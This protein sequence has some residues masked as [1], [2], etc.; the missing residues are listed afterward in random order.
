MKNLIGFIVLLGLS[1]EIYSQ[2]INVYESYVDTIL[3]G[4]HLQM[5]IKAIESYPG[6][7]SNSNIIN[8]FD[9]NT[10]QKFHEPAI[11][12]EELERRK[13]AERLRVKKEIDSL[14]VVAY[15]YSIG[16]TEA[17]ASI[18]WPQYNNY[19]D[20]LD[21][22]LEKRDVVVSKI[23]N[24]YETFTDS[25]YATFI[26]TYFNSFEEEATLAKRYKNKFRAILGNKKLPLLY[27]T[28]YLFSKW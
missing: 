7:F 1:G 4:G 25:Q 6:G 12:R 11:N 20:S 2:Q 8:D 5:S 15:T 28:E 22:I 24:P 17:E 9:N 10:K 18:F 26:D 19:K 14:R 3:D 21:K 27:R 23:C 13:K 16:L